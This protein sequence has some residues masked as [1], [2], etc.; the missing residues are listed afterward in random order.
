MT[1]VKICGITNLNDALAAQRL[2]ADMIGLNFY[3][4]SPRFVS[5]ETAAEI[6]QNTGPHCQKIGVFVNAQIPE[7]LETVSAVALDGIQLH[8]DESSEFAASLREKTSLHLIKAFR[9]GP[10]FSTSDTM[11]HDVDSILLDAFSSS[12]YGG[13]GKTFD[14]EIAQVAAASIS[15]LFLAGGLNPENVADAIRMVLP[16][17]VDTAG[18]VESAPGKKDELRMKAFIDIAKSI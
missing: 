8:G 16:F 3:P 6:S 18:G 7:I 11:D 2:G 10:Q 13:T 4:P 1:K 5:V 15:R 14:W 9:V 17:A 12:G